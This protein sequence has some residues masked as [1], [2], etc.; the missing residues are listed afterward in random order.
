MDDDKIDGRMAESERPTGDIAKFIAE[1][2]Q[3]AEDDRRRNDYRLKRNEAGK[4]HEPEHQ[5]MSLKAPFGQHIAID[6]AQ[7][8]RDQH[9]RP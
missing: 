6:R 4:Q 9:V 7:D 5:R 2:A 3:D 8:R 1:M